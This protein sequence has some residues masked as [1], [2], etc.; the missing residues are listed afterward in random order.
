MP[1]LIAV[2]ES[3][4]GIVTTLISIDYKKWIISFSYIF[5]FTIFFWLTRVLVYCGITLIGLINTKHTTSLRMKT[6]RFY[7]AVF[8]KIFN[9]NFFK[10]NFLNIFTITC[11]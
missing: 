4:P 9:T 7:S 2:I 1:N 10:K 5:Y 8:L 6:N 11:L 3:I